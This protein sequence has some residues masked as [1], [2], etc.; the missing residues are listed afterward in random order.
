[1]KKTEERKKR[2]RRKTQEDRRPPTGPPSLRAPPSASPLFSAGGVGVQAHMDVG[3]LLT[4]ME[5]VAVTWRNAGSSDTGSA[6]WAG[7]SN[8]NINIR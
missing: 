6:R 3:S 2:R 4:G 1:M 8:A 7:R 5:G